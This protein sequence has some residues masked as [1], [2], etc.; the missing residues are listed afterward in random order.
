[1]FFFFSGDGGAVVER[2][3]RCGCGHAVIALVYP[4]LAAEW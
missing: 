1:M 3:G 4:L 2:G